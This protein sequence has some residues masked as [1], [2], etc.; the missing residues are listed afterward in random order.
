MK[1]SIITPMH[2]SF[3]YM[4]RYFSHFESQTYKD[5]ELIIVDDC[6]TDDSYNLLLQ[7]VKKSPLK[8]KYYRLDENMGP[9]V[10]RN[11]ALD[12]AEGEWVTF[13]D[14]D[15]WVKDSMLEEINNIAHE[16]AV[17]CVVYDYCSSD[18]ENDI[19]VVRGLPAYDRGYITSRDMVSYGI[20]G[21]IKCLKLSLINEKRIR[22]PKMKR[23]E[24]MVFWACVF[25]KNPEMKI[26]Y[27]RDIFYYALQRKHSLSRA[28]YDCSVMRPAYEL[29]L[30]EIGQSFR[31]ELDILSIRMILYGE[32][33][34]MC[35][36]NKTR[37]EINEFIEWY[38]GH[39]P[40]WYNNLC[41]NRFS[42]TKKFFLGLIRQRR[43]FLMRV[44][45]TLHAMAGFHS[46]IQRYFRKDS[47]G[48]KE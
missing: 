7:Y 22:Y 31:P 24:D 38:E 39:N 20:A 27:T 2:N 21:H 17:E 4:Q 12:M 36:A 29:L 26:Y 1:Y 40:H 32:V 5:F 23:A 13:V 14:S 3:E 10:A 46:G 18:G 37:S 47:I 19:R 16:Y 11:Y 30:S 43:F 28:I 8:I 25:E 15:D 44:F 33:L 41:I 34:I 48:S 6:S 9:G 45:A 42:V 35:Q